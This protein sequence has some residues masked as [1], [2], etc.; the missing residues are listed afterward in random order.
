M[1]YLDYSITDPKERVR[2]VEKALESIPPQEQTPRLLEYLSNYILFVADKKQTKKERETDYGIT[3]KNREVTINKRQTSYEGM[4]DSLEN[5]EDGLHALINNDKNQLLDHKEKITDEE[6]EA[7]PQ[8]KEQIEII[9]KLNKTLQSVNGRKKFEIKKQIIEQWQ[10]VYI[11]R[12]SL[13]GTSNASHNN[14]TISSKSADIYENITLNDD[15][16]LSVDSQLSLLIP[17]HVSYL[18]CNYSQIKQDT[19]EMLNGDLR[20]IIIGLE[21]LILEMFP[22][23][24]F[25]YNLIVWKIDGD[26]NYEIQEKMKFYGIEHSEQYY[27]STWRQRIPKMIAD[28]AQKKWVIWHFNNEAYGEW[29]QC[30]KCGKW[31]PVHPMFF[32]KNS[33]KNGYY[34]ICKDCRSKK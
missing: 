18:L 16:T 3:T 14:V 31:K 26:S 33:T 2:Q 19:Y 5:G 27:S 30:S 8:L 12:A 13:K 11:M 15:G 34:S 23:D 21:D 1:F 9:E 10:Q 32:G 25:Y 7:Y 24:S 20:W 29:K 4:I 6:I 17:E 22:E 28:Y